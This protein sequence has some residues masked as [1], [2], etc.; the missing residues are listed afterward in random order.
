MSTRTIRRDAGDVAYLTDLV[1]RRAVVAMP[2]PS[3]RAAE[4]ILTRQ[5]RVTAFNVTWKVLSGTSTDFAS[6][7][8]FARWLIAR[9]GRHTEAAVVHDAAYRNRLRSYAA[10]G[11]RVRTPMTRLRADQLFVV[12]M[13]QAG[14]RWWRYTL[15]YWSVRGCGWLSWHH[16]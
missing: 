1:V 9:A 15:M 3:G 14:V 12:L 6:I 16:R 11:I 13:A 7:P 2:L 10:G 4:F 5:F 8:W